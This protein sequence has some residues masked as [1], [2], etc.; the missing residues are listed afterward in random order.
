[1]TEGEKAPLIHLAD[2]NMKSLCNLHEQHRRKWS[3]MPKPTIVYNISAPVHC[4]H[5]SA[6]FA[7]MFCCATG[8]TRVILV[9]GLE[10]VGYRLGS[11]RIIGLKKF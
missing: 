5:A 4:S 8:R 9:Q 1:M 2:H 7:Y 10:T 3:S 11:K 6:I